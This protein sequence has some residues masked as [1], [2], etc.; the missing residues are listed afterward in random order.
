MF[1]CYRNICQKYYCYLNTENCYLND[2]AKQPHN[3]GDDG[4]MA[5]KLDTSKAYDKVEWPS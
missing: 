5:I 2:S 4:F 1:E 3:S